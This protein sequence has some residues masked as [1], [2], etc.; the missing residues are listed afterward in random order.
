MTGKDLAGFSLLEALDAEEREALCKVLERHELARGEILFEEGDPADG[1]LLITEGRVR[2]KCL[3]TG[4]LG[5][6]GEGQTVGTSSLAGPGPREAT[7]VASS[8]ACVYR[9]SRDAFHGLVRDEPRVA[10][11]IAE[12][13]LRELS[14]AVR[15]G[16]AQLVAANG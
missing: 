11:K 2:I 7:A 10:Y 5:E 3:R 13:A 1:M 6:L 9:L 14:D 15:S 4:D 12:A 16:L 8:G